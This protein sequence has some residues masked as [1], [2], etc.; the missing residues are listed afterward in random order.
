M[1]IGIPRALLYYQYGPMWT[2]FFRALG[3]EVVLSP[4]TTKE[5][6]NRGTMLSID[7]TCLSS[8]IYM[9]HVEWLIGKCDRIFVPRIASFGKEGILCTKFE[10]LYDLV[11]NTFRD[12]QIKLLDC[13]IDLKRGKSELSAYLHLGKK[14]GRGRAASFRAYLAAKQAYHHARGNCSQS[15]RE[16][17]RLPDVKILVVAHPYV[18]YDEYVGKPVLE[19][20]R[21]L[22]AQPVLACEA[23]GEQALES[24][25]R[26]TDTLPWTMSRELVGAVALHHRE[27]DGIVLMSAFPCGP[28]SMV[29]EMLLRRL[30]GVPMLHLSVDAQDG[31]A[32]LQTRLESFIDIIHMKQEATYEA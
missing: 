12:R 32:G 21:S 9:G 31:E 30:Q 2:A 24:Y 28:D 14:L 18:V 26:L 25:I 1:K 16:A 3:A 27:V 23:D 4:H 6:L 19:A 29:N 15:L 11:G 20:I 17:L 7:E 22:G 5:T 13:E 10:A 8:K